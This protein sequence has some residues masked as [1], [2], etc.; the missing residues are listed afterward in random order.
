LDI[1]LLIRTPGYSFFIAILYKIFN[2]HD[3]VLIIANIAISLI[4]LVLISKTLSLFTTSNTALIGSLLYAV[5][6]LS[7]SLIFYVL[8]QIL[9][10]SILITIAFFSIKLLKKDWTYK[11][12]FLFGLS[13][14]VASIIKPVGF[15]LISPFVFGVIA[16]LYFQRVHIFF[17]V[18]YLIILFIP[19]ILITGG[20]LYRN[21]SITGDFT[22]SH[23]KALD[24]IYFKAPAILAYKESIPF[25]EARKKIVGERDV[26][27]WILVNPRSEE[28]NILESESISIL[29]DNPYLTSKIL[30][31][32]MINTLFGPGDGQFYS[33]IGKGHLRQG[34]L[35]DIFRLSIGEYYYKWILNK[36]LLFI[37]FLLFSFYLLILYSGVVSFFYNKIYAK[38]EL[39]INLF[40]FLIL[41]YFII[42]SGGL[43]TYYRFRNPMTPFFIILSSQGWDFLLSSFTKSRFK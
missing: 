14:S 13:L 23:I 40:L 31:K 1:P 39:W 38:N 32:G 41:S 43:E 16:F 10:Q 7:L 6:P 5:E 4:S 30:F 25:E 33:V 17:I 19:I 26:W 37:M 8:P 11:I 28:I 22:I 15:Y 35:G 42:I 9:F 3:I 2:V 36:P 12:W 24:L 34:P 29:I 21:F 18:K 27:N 20:W